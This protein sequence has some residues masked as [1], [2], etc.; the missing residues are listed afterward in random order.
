MS[1]TLEVHIEPLTRLEGHGKILVEYKDGKLEN[2]QLNVIEPP[3]FFEKLL[4]DKPGEEAPRISERIC[5]VCPVA[6]HLAAVKAIEDAWDVKP[7]EPAVLLRKLLYAG[8][9]IQ[10]HALHLSVFALPDLLLRLQ[11]KNLIGLHKRNPKLVKAAIALQEY[12]ANLKEAIGG[13]AIHP[14]AAIPGG[15]SKPLTAATKRKLLKNY[16]EIFRNTIELADIYFEIFSTRGTFVKS[17]PPNKTFYLAISHDGNFETYDGPVRVVN[18]NGEVE[19]EFQPK[20]YLSNIAEKTVK[21]SYVKYPFLKKIGY[22]KGLYRVG[23]L[24]RFNVAETISTPK[25]REYWLKLQETFGKPI[26]YPLVY[27]LARVVEL[28][29]AVELSKELLLN[30]KI[31]SGRIRREVNPKEG[32]GVGIVEAPRGTLIHHY[33]TDKD[34]IITRANLI[35]ATGQNVPTIEYGIRAMA[36]K[37]KP[38][39]LKGKTKEAQWKFEVLVRAYDPCISCATHLVEIKVK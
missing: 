37:L 27:N 30:N 20:E 35:V 19:F 4:V 21:H 11:E 36:E 39:I 22:P 18:P 5:G 31:T 12:G 34:G 33:V 7:L 10:S 25:A 29:H 9:F 2:V 16:D 15:M 1:S 13:R 23:P 28:I 17:F 38:A 32:S 8:Q 24:A 6:H 14:V 26:H 3:R